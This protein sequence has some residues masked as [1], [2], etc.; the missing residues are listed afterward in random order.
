MNKERILELADD[1]ENMHYA[2]I[3]PEDTTR[4]DC[5][6]MVLYKF[7]CGAPAC[8][9]GHAVMKYGSLS[10]KTYRGGRISYIAQHLLG[11]T[12]LQRQ[13][14]FEPDFIVWHPGKDE[15]PVVEPEVAAKVLR[16]LVRTGFVE[17]PMDE[18]E[19]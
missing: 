2:A 17:W 6:N 8:L 1:V 12:D 18:I 15:S 3:G 13:L 5:F 16:N 9:A 7:D 11:L 19:D 14:L 4:R 10:Q